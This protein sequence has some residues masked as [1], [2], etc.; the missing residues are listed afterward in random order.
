MKT[1]ALSFATLLL[2]AGCAGGGSVDF[3]SVDFSVDNPTDAPLRLKIDGA[4]YE[5]AAHQ[6]KALALKAGEHSLEAPATGPLK[7][8]VYAGRKGGL[9]NPTLSDYVI[10]SE[11]YVTE[12]SKAKNFMPS[13]GGAF[14][15]DGVAFDGP[16]RHVDGLFIDNDWRFGVREAFPDSLRGYDAGNGGNIFR[17][18][19]TAPDFVAYYEQRTDQ[20]S[21]FEKNRLHGTPATRGL[22]AP[23]P[24]PEFADPATQAA[25]L[26]LREL[27]AQYL[28]ATDPAE[29]KRLQ[30]QYYPLISAFTAAT[31]SLAATRPVAENLK[32]NE[33][34]QRTGE[35]F[36]WSA[37]VEN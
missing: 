2:L 10:V 26:R 29:Q 6:A 19:F 17:K 32:Q 31:A 8:I 7:F 9:I 23:A 36:G 30:D 28:R 12:A 15:L 11:T 33:F 25:S 27:Y 4:D 3:S 37:R 5:I 34:V 35:V 20:P 1:L 14:Q 16:F 18:I 21:F 24:L 13:G 22:T